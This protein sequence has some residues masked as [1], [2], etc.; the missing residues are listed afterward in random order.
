[1]VHNAL[2][3][4]KIPTDPFTQTVTFD[5]NNDEICF[6]PTTVVPG[7]YDIAT[8]TRY[9]KTTGEPTLRTTTSEFLSQVGAL[10]LTKNLCKDVW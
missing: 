10:L 8:G 2:T 4:I 1:M 9:I 7:T 6:S 3:G 5:S